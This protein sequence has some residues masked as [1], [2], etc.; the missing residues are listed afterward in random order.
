VSAVRAGNVIIAACFVAL[1]GVPVLLAPRG[2]APAGGDRLVIITPHNEQIRYEFGRAFAAWHERVHGTRVQVTWSVPGGASE[3]LRML[4]SRFD[5]AAAAGD[6][7][8]GTADLMWGGGS[9][10]HE[11]L[12]APPVPISVPVDFDDAWL[13]SV[14]G[15][16]AI[17]DTRLY[18]PDK[19]WFGT[20]LAAFGIVYNR[21]VL[22]EL[23]VAEPRS[24]RDLADPRLDGW[25]A[26]ADPAHSGSITALY[27]TI[28]RHRGWADGWRILRR[29]GANA[30]GFASSA[31]KAPVDVSLGDA[32]AGL[33]IDFFG[34]YQ[35]QAIAGA[36]GA[37]RVGY[38]D[39]PGETSIDTDPISMLAGAPRPDLARRFIEF[40]LS[41]AGQALWQFP[42]RAAG[43]D[44]GPQRF[45]LRRLPIRR[46]MYARYLDRFVDRVNPY[47][48]AAA[49][50]PGEPGAR[51]H[52]PDLFGAMV[53]DN[54]GP[55][56]A[57]WRA[58]NAEAD[59]PTRRAMLDLFDR[60]PDDWRAQDRRSLRRYFRANYDEILELD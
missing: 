2:A 13:A 50:G 21:D 26:M 14:Y 3:T 30:R 10:V 39:P 40:C 20:V 4:R 29:A 31:L 56:R 34:R 53:I 12:K 28:L 8:G 33:C 45:E 60:M 11:Q 16:N 25:V 48:L 24:W 44:L 9:W 35:A 58:V 22:A 32:A 15:E 46:S 55:L 1:V 57:A 27:E 17:G 38:V 47:A 7:V 59:A 23:G 42:V 18:D 52:I 36:G 49:A 37:R 51:A 43:D 19:Y 6:P 54:H 5:A 41:E